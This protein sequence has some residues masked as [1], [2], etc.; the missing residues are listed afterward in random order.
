MLGVNAPDATSCGGAQALANLKSLFRPNDP[1]AVTYEPTLSNA[2]DKD[3]NTLAYVITGAGVTQDIGLRMV[4]EGFATAS[5]PE[6]QTV[7]KNFSQY[8]SVGKGAVDQKLGIWASC[9]AP[10][11]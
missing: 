11:V 10:K 7:P 3:G 2:T 4:R 9:P 1:V 8:T 6:G 5:Y